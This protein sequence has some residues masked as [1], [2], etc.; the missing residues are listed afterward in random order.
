[1]KVKRKKKSER[2][3]IIPIQ[4]NAWLESRYE[5][6]SVCV[7]ENTESNIHVSSLFHK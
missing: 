3:L 7:Y 1:M 6:N 2:Y 5:P 4:E